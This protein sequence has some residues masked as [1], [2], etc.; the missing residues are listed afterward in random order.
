MAASLI[1][2]IKSEK[3][4]AQLEAL[5]QIDGTKDKDGA[6]ALEQF[7][8][9]L[10]S[11]IHRGEISVQT[12][13]DAPVAAS[14]TWTLAS[15]VDT[16][17]VTV[18]N[19]TLTFATS[20]SGADQLD[21]DVG[22]AKAFAS[23]TDLVLHTGVITE[24]TH[25]YV[26]GDVGQLTTSGALPT[27]FSAST[28]YFVIR[29]DADSYQ[30]ASSY[31]NALAGT[32]IRPTALGTGNQTFTPSADKSLA[33]RLCK[34]VNDHAVLSAIVK[35]TV[36]GAVVTVTCRTPGIIGN[37]IAF[38]DADSTIT[39]SG[40]GYLASGTGGAKDDAVVYTLGL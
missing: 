30:L 37:Y 26:T 28:D 1:A 21:V 24:T 19:T 39:S 11:G 40:S 33:A 16:D 18:A 34:H 25:G 31:A 38:T 22:S 27:G 23:A 29:V 5:L 7:I 6:K 10:R 36:S 15:V 2:T 17:T 9:E 3:T 32:Q 14:G 8:K 12:G 4:V 35:A 20:P 13:S